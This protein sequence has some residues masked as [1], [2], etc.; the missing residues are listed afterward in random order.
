[1]EWDV[2]A[3]WC[4][5]DSRVRDGS[6]WLVELAWQ[7]DGLAWYVGTAGKGMAGSV[8]E[9]RLGAAWPVGLGWAGLAWLV[10]QDKA[11]PGKSVGGPGG[12]GR[13]VGE[14]HGMTSRDGMEKA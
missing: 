5:T 12:L 2:G 8:G 10:G 14:R 3:G 9:G 13:S 1:M 11:W 6:T 7:G 4:G